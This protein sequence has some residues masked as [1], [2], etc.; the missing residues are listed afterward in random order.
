MESFGTTAL[1]SSEPL[2]NDAVMW[3]ASC[4]KL[5][6]SICALQCVERG[7][8]SLDSTEDVERLVP[9]TNNPIARQVF[10]GKGEDGKYKTKPA[11]KRATL[12]HLLTHSSGFAYDFWGPSLEWR[13]MKGEAPAQALTGQEV[14]G[15]CCM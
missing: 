5:L 6:T 14:R 13:M 1:D 11:T 12:R 7:Q 15:T 3:F 2:K 4:T 8:F 9:E 10:D